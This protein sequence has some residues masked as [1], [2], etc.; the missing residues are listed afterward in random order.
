[1][2]RRKGGSGHAGRALK[3][4]LKKAR[5]KEGSTRWLR[6]QL[7]D[8]YVQRANVAGYRSR[9]AFKLI[10]LDDR[11]SLLRPGQAVLDLGAAPGSW[12]QVCAERVSPGRVVGLDLVALEPIPGVLSLQG[13]LLA[14]GSVRRLELALGRQADVV[15]SDLAAPTTGHRVTDHLRTMALAEAAANAAVSLLAVGGSAVIKFFQGTDEADLFGFLQH[16][17]ERVQRVKPAASRSDSIELYMVAR[18]FQG[19]GELLE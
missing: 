1:M 5:R 9:A 8:V 19:D 15:L 17:F 12:S 13:D 16:R 6:R 3:P 11:F 2:T 10:Q 14:E 18:G 4:R 7:S